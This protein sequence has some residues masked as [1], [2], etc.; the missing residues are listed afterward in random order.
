MRTRTSSC[1]M[2][3]LALP[4]LKRAWRCDPDAPENRAHFATSIE[5]KTTYALCYVGL[6]AF[7]ALM[8][9]GV[10]DMLRAVHSAS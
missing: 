4:Q 7:L 3:I 2:A 10:H 8:T 5:T 6:L 9:S 1:V